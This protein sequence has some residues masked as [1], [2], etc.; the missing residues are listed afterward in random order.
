MLT[1]RNHKLLHLNEEPVESDETVR[2]KFKVSKRNHF[3][4]ELLLSMN[5]FRVKQLFLH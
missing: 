1:S 5:F 4:G 2:F 3:V